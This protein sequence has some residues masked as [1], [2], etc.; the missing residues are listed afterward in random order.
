MSAPRRAFSRRA[1][2]GW[3]G[4]GALALAATPQKGKPTMA[5]VPSHDDERLERFY[6]TETKYHAAPVPTPLDRSRA[7]AFV[8]SKVNRQESAEKL[9]KLVRLAVFY[10]L[11]ECAGA[12]KGLLAGG[13]TKP[14]EISRSALALIALAWIGDQ[15]QQASA[16][17][18]YH[19]LQ[20]RADIDTQRNLMLEVV[21]AFGPREGT[22]Y[23]RQWVQSAI[24]SLAQR[25]R[26]AEADHNTA[27]VRLAREKINALT[28]YLNIQLPR[29]DRAFS[30]R[31]RIDAVDPATQVKPLVA[32]ALES[33]SESTPSLAFWASMRLLRLGPNVAG[34]IAAEF[35]RQAAALARPGEELFRARALRAAEFFGQALAE[36][37]SEWLA[38]Q[39]DTLVDPLVLRPDL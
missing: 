23:H 30:I 8:N 6:D 9:R 34:P 31:Q 17:G 38:G 24:A 7:A 15:A 1:A 2:L 22:A 11:R 36:P 18:Y 10:D 35:A 28:E 19:G 20:D 5:P 37:D 21:E 32:L 13:E 3:L 12:F 29:V 25:G 27:G 4:A 16:Q 39:P 14:E 26:Q 33:T